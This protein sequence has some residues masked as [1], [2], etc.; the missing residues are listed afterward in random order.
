MHF[1]QKWPKY[2]FAYA[3]IQMHNYPKPNNKGSHSGHFHTAKNYIER[4]MI[5]LE[6]IS[7]LRA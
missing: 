3:H 2:A 4:K 6:K 5:I 1:Y 7:K